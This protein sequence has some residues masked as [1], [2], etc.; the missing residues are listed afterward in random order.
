MCLEHSLGGSESNLLSGVP[1]V[2]VGSGKERLIQILDHSS[3]AS[4]QSGL[5]SDWSRNK[6]VL[7]T[8]P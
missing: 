1:C 3:V 5:F 6:R 2:F 4:P 7:R 8:K